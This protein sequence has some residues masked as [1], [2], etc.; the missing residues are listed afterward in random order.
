VLISFI[1][2]F[3]IADWTSD[4]KTP[5][6]ITKQ[7][8]AI[9]QIVPG[10]SQDKRFSIPSRKNTSTTDQPD[11][12]AQ[13]QAAPSQAPPSQ[14]PQQSETSQKNAPVAAAAP[15]PPAAAAEVH[16]SSEETRDVVPEMADL[17]IGAKFQSSPPGPVRRTDSQTNDIDEFHDAKS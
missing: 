2:V 1:L 8:L 13:K 11:D 9:T 3:I 17:N 6:E 10:Q 16:P 5:E 12:D 15:P 14:A 7:V 4:G